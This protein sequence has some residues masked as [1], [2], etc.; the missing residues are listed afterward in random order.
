MKNLINQILAE[1]YELDPKFR[2][3]DKELSKIMEKLI[4]SR[5][6]AELDDDFRLK[7]KN[8]VLV[9]FAKIN[10]KKR[11]NLIFMNKLYVAYGVVVLL[12][13]ITVGAV[14]YG[15]VGEKKIVQAPLFESPAEIEKLGERAFGA[16]A[17]TSGG[18]ENQAAGLGSAATA[19]V[20]A[21]AERTQSGGGGLE[22]SKMSSDVAMIMPAFSYEYQYV[23]EEL[24][25]PFEETLPV[26][27]KKS[28]NILN[29]SVSSVLTNLDLGMVNLGSF[30]KKNLQNLSIVE[31]GD[32]GYIIN[33]DAHN[34]RVSFYENYLFWP[35][36]Y[37]D[38]RSES[39]YQ[40]LQL[41]ESDVPSENEL[42]KIADKF[43]VDHNIDTSRY[44]SP[45]VISDWKLNTDY[46]TGKIWV[47]DTITVVYPEKI[48]DEMVRDEGGNPYGVSVAIN[49][50][51]KK[52]S[53]LW[54]LS[55]QSYQRSDY[56]IINDADKIIKIAEQ[57]NWRYPAYR[58]DGANNIIVELDTPEMILTYISIYKE[59]QMQEFYVPALSFPVKGVKGDDGGYETRYI[60]NRRIIVPLVAEIY[61]QVD[62]NVPMPLM[63]EEGSSGLAEPALDTAVEIEP[64][65][66]PE[67]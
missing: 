58:W 16:L 24:P 50:R 23:G 8:Q 27:K 51:Y 34:G 20:S 54:N 18:E 45:E 25:L 1:L 38:C 32:F 46:V 11:I 26:Y 13:V 29:S 12:L 43:F 19:P 66:L 15:F 65:V 59:N 60:R 22:S 6:I 52:V 53:S 5:P 33:I 42:I 4:N 64:L 7:L 3:H 28:E 39:C 41:A 17:L 10:K 9:E 40:N 37:E 49:I 55:L 56:E 30:G 61:E 35:N 21:N 63:M 57:G 31:E 67:K 2:D 44:G 48:N 47:P 36:P 62:G 14:Y